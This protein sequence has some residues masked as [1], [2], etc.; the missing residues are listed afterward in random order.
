MATISGPTIQ[1]TDTGMNSFE[2]VYFAMIL[3]VV[4]ESRHDGFEMA[5]ESMLETSRWHSARSGLARSDSVVA[6]ALA[7]DEYENM[8]TTKLRTRLLL[9]FLAVTVAYRAERYKGKDIGTAT[10]FQGD[11]RISTNVQTKDGARA[12]GTRVS[13][14]VNEQVLDK[15]LPWVAQAFVVNAWYK[16]A[17]EPI[18]DVDGKTIG[19]LYVGI[20]EQPFVDMAQN[21]LLVYMAI[22][23]AAML[24]AAFLGYVLTG[25][26]VRPVGQMAAA[27]RQLSRGNLGYTVERMT[28]TAELDTLTASFNEMSEQLREREEKL[29]VVNEQLAALNKT[30]LDLVG[31]VSHELKGIIAT[32]MMN[33]ALVR[34]DYVGSVNEK[35]KKSLDAAKRSLDYLAE[36]VRKF[37]DLSRIEKGELEIKKGAVLLLED[38]FAPCLETFAGEIGAKQMD[39]NQGNNTKARW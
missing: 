24:L 11:L 31:F 7:C 37:P 20:L 22:V 14:Q 1:T 10:I 8:K 34:D 35:Q 26:I 16:T 33:V 18:K 2:P 12:I 5:R 17:Y 29:K 27:T 39:V 6:E 23:A 19:I 36:T 4:V 30:Y 21:I 32:I 3:D 13:A 38:I 25:A 9:S 15:G 28:G